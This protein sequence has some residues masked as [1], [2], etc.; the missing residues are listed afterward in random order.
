MIIIIDI[1]NFESHEFPS[2]VSHLRSQH[3][4]WEKVHTNSC[5]DDISDNGNKKKI[6]KASKKNKYVLYK[7]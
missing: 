6:L 2:Q 5:Y 3:H 4:K 1:P 7:G